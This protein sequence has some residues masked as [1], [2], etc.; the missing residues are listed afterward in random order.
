MDSE[1]VH[2]SQQ[3]S[4]MVSESASARSLS[5]SSMTIRSAERPVT[6]APRPTESSPPRCCPSG[7]SISHSDA[8]PL[9]AAMARP[10]SGLAL[11]VLRIERPLRLASPC[12]SEAP[13]TRV[14]GR[15]LRTQRTK[16]RSLVDFPSCGGIVMMS[17]PSGMSTS[18]CSSVSMRSSAGVWTVEGLSR[19]ARVPG[20]RQASASACSRTG[21]GARSSKARAACSHTLR[22]SVV[23][24]VSPAPRYAKTPLVPGFG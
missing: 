22:G 13:T 24:A 15:F 18:F 12:A 20:V 11:M 10:S 1:S 8:D 16:S 2:Q 6:P 14:Q 19:F 4:R 5:G 21:S 3:A 23:T 17:R 9:S 7:R